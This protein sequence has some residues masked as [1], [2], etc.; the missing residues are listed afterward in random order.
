MPDLNP[1]LLDNLW[2]VVGIAIV[3]L[4]VLVAWT[5]ILNRRLARATAAYRS[6][7]DEASGRS[8][9]EVLLAQGLKV[10]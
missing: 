10:D 2:I 4:V 9:G 8:L 6:L 7:A 5:V 3:A 1:W